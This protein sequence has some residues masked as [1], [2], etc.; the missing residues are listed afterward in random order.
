MWK[1]SDDVLHA[2]LYVH[3][4]GVRDCN[5]ALLCAHGRCRGVCDLCDDASDHLRDDDR[6]CLDDGD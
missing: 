3:V 2:D 4:G 1:F 5:Y 6:V